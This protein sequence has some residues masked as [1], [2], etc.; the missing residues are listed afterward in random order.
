MP[1]P[2]F[3]VPAMLDFQMT[4]SDRSS[5]MSVFP[6]SLTRQE[7]ADECDI[8]V[9]MLRYEATG[10]ISHVNRAQPVYMDLT[11]VPDLRGALDVMRE[12]TL[13]FNS[14]PAKVRREFD[15]DPQ[16]FVDYAQDPANLGKMREWGLAP[17]PAELPPP[18]RVEVV[19]VPAA[20]AAPAV[21]APAPPVV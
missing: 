16:K 18:L 14:L 9:L 11:Q 8:N 10:V 21:P 15:Y 6:P 4:T 1:K 13:A 3:V 2:S 20:P 7:F 12:A 19:P 17:P 5:D